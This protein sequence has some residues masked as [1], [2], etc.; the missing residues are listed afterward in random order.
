MY[1]EVLSGE[2]IKIQNSLFVINFILDFPFNI[3]M[4]RLYASIHLPVCT[5]YDWFSSSVPDE[6]PSS[7][8]TTRSHMHIVSIDK[9]LKSDAYVKYQCIF[10]QLFNNTLMLHYITFI[11]ISLLYNLAFLISI[12]LPFSSIPM[13]PLKQN[14]TREDF[15]SF[16]MH[17]YWLFP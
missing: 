13:T 12:Y 2:C 10:R 3:D 4:I 14:S 7:I 8:K 1:G 6:F 5:A 17:I 15:F 16:G 9:T 11:K